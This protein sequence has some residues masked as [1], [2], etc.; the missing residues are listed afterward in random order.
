VTTLSADVG[1]GAVDGSAAG[2]RGGAGR[3]AGD[4]IG[5]AAVGA[6]R[7]AV[8]ALEVAAFADV[9]NVPVIGTIRRTELT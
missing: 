3:D 4:L 7:G 8:G 5:D 1:R 9:V 2:G 6:W